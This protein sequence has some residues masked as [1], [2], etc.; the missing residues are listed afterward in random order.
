MRYFFTFCTA[1]I[2]QLAIFS[3]E[4][5]RAQCIN[6]FPHLQNFDAGAAGWTA[7]PSGPNGW[8]LGTPNK[9]VINAPASAPNSWITGFTTGGYPSNRNAFV[10]SPCYDFSALINPAISLS[11]FYECETSF[12]G[13]A[14]FS[15][16]DNGATWQL[17]GNYLDPVNWYNDN[18]LNGG[19]AGGPGGQVIG[20]SGSAPQGTGSNGWVL[21]QRVV[22][23]LAGQ[24]S[25]RFR[26]YFDSDNGPVS[27]N[28]DGFAFDDFLVADLPVVELGNDTVICFADT[29]ILDAGCGNCDFTWSSSALDTLQTLVV[30]KSG[31]YHVK[32]VDSLGFIQRDTVQ[33]TVSPT[34][35]NLGPDVLICPGDTLLLDAGN[36]WATHLWQPGSLTSQTFKVTQTGT[37]SVRVQDNYNCV[38]RDSI[39]VFVDFVPVVD[40]GND[41]T[42]CI[43]QS[44]VLDA[45]QGNPGTT[46]QWNFGTANTQTI[47]V[48]APG[49]Y[50]VLLTTQAGCTETDT[51]NISVSLSPVVDLG[52]DRT[53][54]GQYTL[55]A[56]N[57]GA[58]YLWSTGDTTQT[59]SRLGSGTYWVRVTNASGCFDADT[60]NITAGPIP[61]VDL[62]PD[63]V[64]CNNNTVTLTAGTPNVTYFWSN[65]ASTPSITVNS[66]GTYSVVVTNSSGCQDT[67]TVV[68]NRSNLFVNLGNDRTVCTGDQ[69]TLIAGP[70]GPTYIWSNGGLGSSIVIT[71]GGTY[72]VTATDASGCVARDTVNITGHPTPVPNFTSSGTFRMFDPVQFTDQTAGNPTAWLWD[73]GDGAT[74]TVRNPQH[75]YQAFGDFTVT[76]RVTDGPCIR[77]ISKTVTIDLFQSLEETLGLDLRVY[78]NPADDFVQV[79]YA[80]DHSVAA[81]LVL[82]DLAGHTLW[83][84]D[85]G[86]QTQG[87]EVIPTA[88]LASGMYFLQFEVEAGK[89][90][91]KI[92]VE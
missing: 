26:M 90:F 88:V 71:T 70:S 40:L 39:K 80:L 60:V 23:Q 3:P 73:F 77:T 25:V 24:P 89:V 41:T 63:R 91:R 64:I 52:P 15:S 56:N 17:V 9:P 65:G 14:L 68:I 59:I 51:V 83:A 49:M 79:E 27:S 72:S 81:R 44:V 37:Y 43:G 10:T 48:S 92:A 78:P 82:T 47:T 86:F 42:F 84:K 57:P 12:D 67:D 38:E 13:A 22:P 34:F 69:T 36:P 46:Y 61:S 45:G 1:V 8:T 53:T 7:S 74:A 20:W 4:V 85:I 29:V 32:V 87:L 28:G 6:T 62:G 33:I 18:S 55:S 16:I 66:P 5:V 19:F 35:V 2:C 58:K 30:V 21:A 75:T 11:I 54:C 76:L 50:T 31:I